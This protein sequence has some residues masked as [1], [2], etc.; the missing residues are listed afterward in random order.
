M[1][2]TFSTCTHINT[3]FVMVKTSYSWSILPEKTATHAYLHI[4]PQAAAFLCE[5]W[6]ESV[7]LQSVFYPKRKETVQYTLTVDAVRIWSCDVCSLICLSV[8][9][10]PAPCHLPVCLH[11][12]SLVALW[13]RNTWGCCS[14]ARLSSPRTAAGQLC[15][16]ERTSRT[17]PA[18]DGA[19][20]E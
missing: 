13:Q 2:E 5:N 7:Q 16:P 11:E 14:I 19:G 17:A 8:C 18:S 20:G 4:S 10:L 3:H 15:F 12:P 9:H 6:W 1:G